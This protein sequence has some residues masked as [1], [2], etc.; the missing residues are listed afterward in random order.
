MIGKL[1]MNK[2]TVSKL[3]SSLT[4]FSQKTRFKKAL[5]KNLPFKKALSENQY[6]ALELIYQPNDANQQLINQIKTLQQPYQSTRWLQ[7]THLQ[8][9][10]L[11][12]RKKLQRPLVYDQI[13]TLNL[14][15]GG[16][17]AL[18]WY[19]YQLPAQTPTIVIMHT[20]TGT[21]K[22]MQ[23][24]VTDL[25]A[26]TGWRV[27][28]AVRRGHAQLDFDPPRFNI[29]GS[30]ADL[31]QQLAR[32]EQLFPDSPLYAVG[33]SAG[34]GLLIRY[35]GEEQA[36]TKFKAAFAFCPGFNIDEGFKYCHPFYSR[37]MTQKLIKT[38]ITPHQ[39]NLQHLTTFESLKS[40]KTLLGFHEKMYEFSGYTDYQA[41]SAA[42]NPMKVFKQMTCPVMV[43]NAADDPVCHIEN[44]TPYLPEIRQ[45]SNVI[46]VRTQKGSHCA[47]PEGW[48][49]TSWAHR[50]MADYF[51][52]LHQQ[53]TS[54]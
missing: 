49:A 35:L 1:M 44:A 12:L 37:Y 6:A 28:V 50:L 26:A 14:T 24:M 38:F 17:L 15:D 39:H 54:D 25:H 27:V 45:M 3:T 2:P 13:E 31:K 10:L 42:T 40:A 41:Y 48:Q 11:E 22:S 29:F 33:S 53:S 46:L 32:I 4:R 51:Q 5:S 20:L 47:Y 23:D 34:S 9:L 19:G 30:T 36:N 21:P 43:L 18:A 7:N 8:L 16:Q 52:T